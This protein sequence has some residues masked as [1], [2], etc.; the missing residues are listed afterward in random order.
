[1]ASFLVQ[2]AISGDV[3]KMIKLSTQ[4]KYIKNPIDFYNCYTFSDS[5]ESP[6]R[7]EMIGW[8]NALGYK[9]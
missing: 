6:V 9:Y 7:E 1:M 4:C 3:V 5:W 2:V 8:L